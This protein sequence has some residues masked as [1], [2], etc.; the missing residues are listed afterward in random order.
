MKQF[1]RSIFPKEFFTD[2]AY[3]RALVLVVLYLGVAIAQLFTYEKFAGVIQGF[4][5]PGSAVTANVLAVALP[6]TAYAALPFLLSMRTG[7]RLRAVSRTA[8]VMVP[9]L[10]LIIALWLNF[11]S[12]ASKLNAGIFGATI[13]TSAGLWTIAFT[14]LWVWAAVIVIRELPVRK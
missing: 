3:F 2:P 10:W 12:N 14:L 7:A 4:G 9:I 8:V 11:A 1:I 13:P 6:L 5:L